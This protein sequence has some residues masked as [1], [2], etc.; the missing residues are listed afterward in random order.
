MGD[1]TTLLFG[2]EGF[3]VVS[4]SCEHE[5]DEKHDDVRQ[6]VVE[7]VEDEQACRVNRAAKL[8]RDRS[9]HRALDADHR[10]FSSSASV[11][12][13]RRR[14][15]KFLRIDHT[16]EAVGRVGTSSTVLEAMPY[17]VSELPP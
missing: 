9:T 16:S 6:V 1:A 5:H 4:V 10:T 7:G 15:P 14:V 2:L 3:R 17:C 11:A 12:S 13:P 8:S